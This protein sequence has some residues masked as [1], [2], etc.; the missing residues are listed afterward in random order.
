MNWKQVHSALNNFI[1]NHSE[2][3]INQSEISIPKA[4]RD[5]FYQRFDDLRR[6]VVEVHSTSLN[7]DLNLLS[8]SYC[9]IEKEV[10]DLLKLDSISMP[11]DLFAF[12][13]SPEDGLMRILYNRT[14]DLLQGKI[15]IDDY[16]EQAAAELQSVA[17]E[18]FRL[19][20]EQWAGLAMIKQLDPDEAYFVDL[21]EDYKP[22]LAELKIIA[23]GRQAHHPTIRIPEFV[24]HSGKLNKYVA[25]KMMLASEIE[26]YVAQF[27]PAVRP[28]KKTGDTSFALDSRIM[29]LSLMESKKDIPIIA[30][31]Y[32]L[33]RTSPDLVMGYISG[34]EIGDP[35][36]LDRVNRNLRALN[37]KI[38]MCMVVVGS[39]LEADI[40][41][42]PEDV[43]TVAT[44]FDQSS[45]E[46]VIETI[47]A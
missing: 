46:S 6:A 34:N 32:E 12:V 22:C 2:I 21:D 4:L 10:V 36:A 15:T 43:K 29:L 7:S 26:T 40:A 41:N 19:G 11:M 25:V 45:F 38:G 1:K 20:Y 35:V 47:T 27:K 30:D 5:E 37:P 13:H 18:L 8:E 17:A 42:I 33:K 39:C 3:V 31:I 14:F 24:L 23:F 16:E 44:G 9:R 28:R